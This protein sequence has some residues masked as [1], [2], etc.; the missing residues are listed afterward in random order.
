MLLSGGRVIDPTQGLDRRIDVRVEGA[1]IIELGEHLKPIDGE[2]VV[3]AT[4]AYVAPGFVDM[5]VHLREPGFPQKETISTGSAAAV[6][7]GFTAVACMPNTDPAIDCS[8]VVALIQDA[9]AA[10]GLTRV[11]P[12]AAITRGRAGRELLDYAAL[13]AAGAVAFS[14]DGQT[15]DDPRVLFDAARH[16][17]NTEQRF[18][19]HCEDERLKNSAAPEVAEDIVV[20]RDLIIAGASGKRWHIAHVSTARSLELIRWARSHGVDVTCEVTP[21]HLYFTDELAAEWGGRAKVNPSLRSAENAAAIREGVL[22][23]T[24]DAFAT[25]HAPHAAH[26]KRGDSAAPGFSGLEVAVGAYALALPNLQLK[27]YVE[28]L[29]TNPARILGI[30]GGSLRLGSPA[31]ITVFA[32][33]PWTVDAAKFYSKGRCTPFDGRQLPRRATATIVDGRLVMQNGAVLK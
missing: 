26:E 20:G 12:I 22:D 11:Y 16:A 8:D 29:S 21:H 4:D 31:D 10:A 33:Q 9:A 6:A 27:R 17:L 14:D 24:V 7:G 13:A 2:T 15:V 23:D 19:S 18:I 3:D 5:H 30:Q 25:D 32:D 28:L 1:R